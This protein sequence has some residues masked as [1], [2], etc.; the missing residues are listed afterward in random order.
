MDGAVFARSY[1]DGT[2]VSGY[3][4]FDDVTVGGL[5]VR[6]Q[7]LALV[8]DTY[9]YG[10]GETSGLLGLAYPLRTGVDGNVAQ[11]NPVFTSMWEDGLTQPLFALGLSRDPPNTTITATATNNGSVAAPTT[12]QEASYMAFGGLPPVDYDASTWTRTPILGMDDEPGWGIT[13]DVK[14]LY[15]ISRTRTSTAN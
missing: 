2:Y 3:F 4:G 10:D 1:V 9:W 15:L 6:H 11:Y 8:N 14:G 13:T 7:Q 5:T 12:G